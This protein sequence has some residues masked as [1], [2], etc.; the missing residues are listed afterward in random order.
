V[1]VVAPSPLSGFSRI[2]LSA[3]RTRADVAVPNSVPVAAFLPVLLRQI[4]QD[5]EVG[6]PGHGGWRLCRM[7]GRRLDLTR[8]MDANEVRDGDVLVLQPMRAV[9]DEPLFD[10][11]VELV[12]KNAVGERWTT[13]ERR[14]AAAVVGALAAL[15]ALAALARMPRHG[16]LEASICVAVAI[17]LLLGGLAVSRAAGDLSGG[18]FVATIAGPYAAVGAALF[19]SGD[20]NRNRLLVACAALLLVAAV[21]PAVVG[22][23][24]AV[25]GGYA[26]VAVF[27]A[28]GGLLAAVGHAGATRPAALIAPLALATTTV[29]P[30][31]SLR[32]ARLPRPQLALTAP[33]LAE[34]PGEVDQAATKER[35]ANARALLTGLTSGALAVTGVGCI[36]LVASGDVWARSL[37]GVLVALVFLRARLYAAR[38][39]VMI[40]VLAGTVALVGVGVWSL[41]ES[42]VRPLA[43]AAVVAGVLAVGALVVGATAGRWDASPRQRRLVDTAETLLLVSVAPLVLG[44]W[45]VYSK[46]F[47]LGD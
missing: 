23:Y 30:P 28:L 41:T 34:L 27:G 20:W 40:A 21:L 17:V 2:T 39:P 36:V 43:V 8:S 46:I 24:E 29:L 15:S 5:T 6:V 13:P 18:G 26:I 11:V 9:I 12:G 37:A 31:L 3:P 47:H 4:G 25:A 16:V 38:Q 19:L 14:A 33:E 35:V 32:L 42:E 45:N 1:P 7:D 10:D 22:G 44:V